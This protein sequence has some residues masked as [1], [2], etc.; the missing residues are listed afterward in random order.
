MHYDHISFHLDDDFP[1][2]LPP[3]HAIHHIG[4]YFAWAVS[5]NL[6]SESAAAL[7]QFDLLQKGLIS[8]SVFVLN[9]LG[10][11]IDETCFSDMGNRFTQFYY[12]DDDEG[13]G[14]FLTDYFNTLN[15][16]DETEFYI[17]QDTAENQKRLNQ[18]FQAAFQTWQQSLQA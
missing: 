17:T 5:Q 12:H 14:H 9:Q 16:K 1:E 11:G 15:L 6:H 13:Y 4:F 2:N 3:Q 18:T 7:P 8:G 10:C